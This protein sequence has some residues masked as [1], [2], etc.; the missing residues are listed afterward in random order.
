MRMLS[1]MDSDTRK[2]I[3]LIS[4]NA[5]ECELDKQGRVIIPQTLLN[6]A[7]VEKD[8]VVIGMLNWIEVWNPNIYET[9]HQNFDLEK[10]AGQMVKF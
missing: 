1:I 3:R 7:Q 2:L 4:G 9:V 5:H 10:T 6:F 8:I